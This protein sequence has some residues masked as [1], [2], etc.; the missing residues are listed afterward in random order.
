MH[1]DG[2]LTQQVVAL[3]STPGRFFTK[4]TTVKNRPGI[5]YLGMR[6]I[7]GQIALKKILWYMLDILHS[8]M[9]PLTK[10]DSVSCILLLT[11]HF[12]DSCS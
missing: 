6:T 2:V 11:V 12:S 10:N 5:N 4:I 7:L 9:P 3:A 1:N 8:C